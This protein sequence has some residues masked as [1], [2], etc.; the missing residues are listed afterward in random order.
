VRTMKTLG[1][2]DC[3]GAGARI[4]LSGRRLDDR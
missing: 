2:D 3:A 1:N 4:L